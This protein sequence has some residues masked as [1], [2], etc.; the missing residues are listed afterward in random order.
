MFIKYFKYYNIIYVRA[1]L[2]VLRTTIVENH[3]LI[4]FC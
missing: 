4:R 1:I 2:C 3:R